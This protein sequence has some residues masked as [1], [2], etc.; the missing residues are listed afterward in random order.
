VDQSD[1]RLLCGTE[2]AEEG[3]QTLLNYGPL[4]CVVIGADGSA[5]VRMDSFAL[6]VDRLLSTGR[7]SNNS[8][9]GFTAAFLWQLLETGAWRAGLQQ[10]SLQHSLQYASASTA[11]ITGHPETMDRFP[12]A[13]S[14]HTFVR[15]NFASGEA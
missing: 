7:G 3:S 10:G 5:Y 4:G 11:L 14:L 8:R 15:L 9:A 6:K 12:D 2:D 13:P 1:L